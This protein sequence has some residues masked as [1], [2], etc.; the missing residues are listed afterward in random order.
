MARFADLPAPD[1]SERRILG[2]SGLTVSRVGFGCYRIG[3]REPEHRAALRAAL[4]GGCNLIDTSTNY[5]DGESEQCVGVVL[6]ELIAAGRIQRE[7]VVLVS[8]A[9]YVQGQN[10]TLAAGRKADGRPF[11]EMVEYADDCWHCI[12]PEFLRDQLARSLERLG[13][14]RLD[15]YLLHNPEYFLSDALKRA[16]GGSTSQVREQFYER[17][18]EAFAHL[19]EEVMAGRLHCYGVSSNTFPQPSADP[20]FVSASQLLMVAREVARARHGDPERHHFSVLQM[21]MNLYEGGAILEPNHGEEAVLEFAASRDLGV[22]V[23]RPLNAFRGG[24]VRLADFTI[25]AARGPAEDLLAAVRELEAEFAAAIGVHIQLANGRGQ[26]L[27]RW[28]RD[29]AEAALLTNLLF[30]NET[31]KYRIVPRVYQVVRALDVKLQG[32]LSHVWREWWSRYWPALTELLTAIRATVAAR[33]QE[34]SDQVSSRLNPLLPVP[35]RSHTL[36][37]KSIATLAAT[38]GVTAVLVGMRTPAYVT[39]TLGCLDLPEW[40]ASRDTYRAF[41]SDESC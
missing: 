25:P 19:E 14:Q 37:R 12:H 31:E 3:K 13:V 18:R 2:R 38:P 5:T 23:N 1:R 8:K 10:L 32:D 15:V 6:A 29:L 30:W 40:S 24:L 7:D 11:P 26:D 9:G 35:L 28:G 20:E 34:L 41:A 17:I 22:L 33:N 21:P 4:L 36:S 27:F 16:G 39:D